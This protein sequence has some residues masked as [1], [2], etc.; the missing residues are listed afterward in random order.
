[1][2]YNRI[3]LDDVFSFVVDQVAQNCIPYLVADYEELLPCF[4][5][6]LQNLNDILNAINSFFVQQNKGVVQLSFIS[7]IFEL[8]MGYPCNHFH[9]L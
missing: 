4:F 9:S 5:C 7:Y 2:K 1:M 8:G 6:Y 3:G